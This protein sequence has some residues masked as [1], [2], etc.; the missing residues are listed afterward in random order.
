MKTYLVSEDT[1]QLALSA[2]EMSKPAYI[3]ECVDRH[4]AATDS[5][6]AI[7]NAPEAEPVA[8]AHK[9]DSR[10]VLRSVGG[11]MDASNWEPLYRKDA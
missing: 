5:L 2:L 11:M 10:A 4:D 7:L 6:R 8:W 3:Q 1:L 9:T